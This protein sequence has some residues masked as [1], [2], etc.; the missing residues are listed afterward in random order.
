[1][2]LSIALFVV[3]TIGVLGGAALIGLPALGGAIIFESLCLGVFAWRRDDG[4]EARPGVHA[5]QGPG[6]HGVPTLRDVLER[7]RAL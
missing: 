6:V 4:Q 2:K 3:A 7:A 5:V 1:M